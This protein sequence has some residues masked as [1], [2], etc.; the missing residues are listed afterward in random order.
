MKLCPLAKIIVANPIILS[1]A[2]WEF[3]FKIHI[4]RTR[5]DGKWTMS[6]RIWCGGDEVD[7]DG[8]PLGSWSF[9]PLAGALF[10]DVFEAM[11]AKAHMGDLINRC[12]ESTI[13]IETA[14]AI[15]H[16]DLQPGYG[17]SDGIGFHQFDEDGDKDHDDPM[18]LDDAFQHGGRDEDNTDWL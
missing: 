6:R 14:L 9:V 5:D 15:S 2:A 17:T 18:G 11:Q 1:E 7:E 3:S 16:E 12:R 8:M 13:P 10:D 4:D